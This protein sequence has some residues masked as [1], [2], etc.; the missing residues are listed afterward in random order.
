VNDS[1]GYEQLKVL[2]PKME[3]FRKLRDEWDPNGIF[4]NDYVNRVLKVNK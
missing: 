3:E 4:V 1:L 2:Y